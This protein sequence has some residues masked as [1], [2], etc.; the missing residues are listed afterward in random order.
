VRRLTRAVCRSLVLA[1]LFSHATPAASE[2]AAAPSGTISEQTQRDLEAEMSRD[3]AREKASEEQWVEELRERFD[4]NLAPSPERAREDQL[5]RDLDERLLEGAQPRRSETVI[6]GCFASLDALGTR[7][8]D[9]LRHR[10]LRVQHYRG[11]EPAGPRA[12]RDAGHAANAIEV[13][14]IGRARVVSSEDA[15]WQAKPT[16][17]EFL[18]VFLRDES[19]WNPE[20][21]NPTWRLRHEQVH[22][23][24]AE[25][26][27]RDTTTS[28]RDVLDLFRGKGDSPEAAIADL[29]RRCKTL[30]ERARH[31]LERLQAR[32]DRETLHGS[33]AVAQANWT[34]RAWA[35]LERN[36]ADS[37][38]H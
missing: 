14:C 33:D 17:L 25:V 35:G 20:V 16:R 28:V 13:T 8:G 30:L 15:G 5:D 27:A 24:L 32:Y 3:R 2:D 10:V 7:P 9:P 6:P 1:P 19:W 18:A 12:G 26:I 11:P 23:D 38:S 21:P 4:R 34:R 31:D 29:G 22:F 36:S 37:R